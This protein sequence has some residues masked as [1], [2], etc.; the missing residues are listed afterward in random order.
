MADESLRKKYPRIYERY[1]GKT[2][3]GL[4][5]IIREFESLSDEDKMLAIFDAMSDAAEATA[6]LM[7]LK[8]V[9]GIVGGGLQE[10]KKRMEGAD[11]QEDAPL[12][13]KKGGLPQ[14]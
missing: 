10:L 2:Q 11:G 14:A 8:A 12:P 9:A 6:A 7:A 4:D 13:P 3:D 1:E 5:E